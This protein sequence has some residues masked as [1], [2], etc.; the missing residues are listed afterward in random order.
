M[1]YNEF[2]KAWCDFYGIE[3]GSIVK[4]I[5]KTESYSKGWT[6]SWVDDMSKNIGNQMKVDEITLS[7]IRLKCEKFG[8]NYPVMSLEFI[9]NP[10]N[11]INVKLNNNYT[12]EVFKDK[13]VVDCQEFSI[14]IL[15]DLN[16]AKETIN[17]Q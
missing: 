16:K 8:F 14:S 11:S 6:N 15:D 3:K 7:G 10:E 4:V 9:S 17:N 2:Q 1:D 5:K 12:A 13:V